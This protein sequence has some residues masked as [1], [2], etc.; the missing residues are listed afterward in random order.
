MSPSLRQIGGKLL[1]TIGL[2][3]PLVDHATKQATIR[4]TAQKHGLKV[5]V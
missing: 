1:E 2:R 5:L 4:N 3:T